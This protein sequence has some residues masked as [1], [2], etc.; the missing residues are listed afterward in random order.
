MPSFCKDISASQHLGPPIRTTHS[1]PFN[2]KRPQAAKRFGTDTV[3]DHTLLP[4][5]ITKT[6]YSTIFPPTY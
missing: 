2:H 4:N 5:S 3:P 6:S 1:Q